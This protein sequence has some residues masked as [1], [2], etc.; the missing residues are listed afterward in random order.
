MAEATDHPGDRGKLQEVVPRVDQVA[1]IRDILEDER[2]GPSAETLVELA[3]RFPPPQK[4]WD[5][6]FEGF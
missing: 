3:K 4:W 1:V 2:I 6:D 5:E